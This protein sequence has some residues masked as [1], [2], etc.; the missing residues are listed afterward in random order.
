MDKLKKA[1]QILND[2][3][4]IVDTINQFFI[5]KDNYELYTFHQVEQRT[6]D[7]IKRV[8]NDG[9]F[10]P[11]YDLIIRRG[12]PFFKD[13]ASYIEV[14]SDTIYGNQLYNEDLCC[15]GGC[16]ENIEISIDDANKYYNNCITNVLELRKTK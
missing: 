10:I 14:T 13:N 16:N 8:E 4:I 1:N 2:A 6:G 9:V 15:F 12:L 11:E 5:A 7:V 3:G